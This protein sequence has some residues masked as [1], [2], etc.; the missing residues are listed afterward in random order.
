MEQQQIQHKI[1]P[2]DLQWVARSDKTEVSPHFDQKV[3]Q[4]CT[5]PLCR[6]ASL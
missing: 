6:S 3:F 2:A 1:A 4:F 5:N